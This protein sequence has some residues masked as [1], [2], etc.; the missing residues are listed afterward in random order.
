M[1]VIVT[2]HVVSDINY[3]TL[4]QCVLWQDTHP[5]QKIDALIKLCSWLEPDGRE[6]IKWVDRLQGS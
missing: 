5:Y 3:T 4:F 6:K 2:L 1:H